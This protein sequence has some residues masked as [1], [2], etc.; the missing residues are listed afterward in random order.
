MIRNLGIDIAE[1][2]RF[3]KLPYKTNKNFYN[4]IFT[5]REIKYCLTKT[6]P[7]QHFTARF[8]AKEAVI[9]AL[10]K[11]ITDVRKIEI[12]NDK[13]GKPYIKFQV[14]MPTGRQ[15]SSKFHVLVSL[16]HAKDYA[17]AIVF[18]YS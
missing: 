15:A 3:R 9:K 18:V 16:S 14:S 7:Y 5:D 4:K 13:N 6:D 17:V 10:N 12:L 1:V 11:K 2:G 8:A